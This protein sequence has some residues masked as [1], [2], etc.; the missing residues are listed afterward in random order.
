MD[1]KTMVILV[2]LVCASVVEV[3]AL[4]L[5]YDGYLLAGFLA[6][7]GAVVGVPAGAVL[8]ERKNR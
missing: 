1:D 4:F 2:A 7:I 5:G 8:Q 6:I 3:V